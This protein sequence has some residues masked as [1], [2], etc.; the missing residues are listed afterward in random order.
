MLSCKHLKGTHTYEVLA[1]ELETINWDFGI[2]NKI[3]HITTDHGSNFVKAFNVYEKIAKTVEEESSDE[4]RSSCSGGNVDE[5]TIQPVR[6]LPIPKGDNDEEGVGV[7]LPKHM[8]C[9]SHILN[10]VATTDAGKTL[11]ECAIYKKFYRSV[12]AKVQEIWNKQSRS[13]KASDV[14]KNNIGFLL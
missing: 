4:E 2:E 13:S 10:L 1:K 11:N 12:L 9:A 14:I 6:L 7:F 3:V 8:S 5:D